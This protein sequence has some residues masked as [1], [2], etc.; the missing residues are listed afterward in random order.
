[1]EITQQNCSFWTG[2]EENDKDQE[3]EA[4]HEVHLMRP[5]NKNDSFK[6]NFTVHRKPNPNPCKR[7]PHFSTLS[8]SLQIFISPSSIQNIFPDLCGFWVPRDLVQDESV[9]LLTHNSLLT[10]FSIHLRPVSISVIFFLHIL[11]HAFFL[12]TE[13]CKCHKYQQLR[14]ITES[15]RIKYLFAFE[16][17]STRSLPQ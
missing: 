9:W 8:N 2:D 7:W 1:M 15:H 12:V 13:G 16:A 17:L 11:N 3:K 5:E 14:Y 10:S 4:K 6:I